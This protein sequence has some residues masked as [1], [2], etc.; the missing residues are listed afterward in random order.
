MTNNENYLKEEYLLKFITRFVS[1]IV[2]LT[3]L[4]TT[5][6]VGLSAN[7][8]SDTSSHWAKEAIN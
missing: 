6:S 3:M 5:M 2:L 4:I 7:Y 8:Y 1:V